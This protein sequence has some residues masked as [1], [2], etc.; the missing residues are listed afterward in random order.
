MNSQYINPL[1][2]STINVLTTMAMV[3]VTAG[4]PSIKQDT[5]NLG[6]ITSTIDLAGEEKHGSL[7]ICFSEPAILNITENMLGESL[8]SI[9]DTVADVVGEITNMITGSAKRI[10]SDQGLE[11]DL[12]RP[13]T[14][15]GKDNP[16]NHTVSGTTILMPF[17]TKAGAFYVE[18]CFN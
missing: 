5:N 13:T 15:I 1:L 14:I 9:D 16:V 10:Y 8:N 17:D 4:K 12:T 3:E 11:F 18:V 2:E 6:D 7:A